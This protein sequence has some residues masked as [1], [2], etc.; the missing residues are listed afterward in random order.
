MDVLSPEDDDSKRVHHSLKNSDGEYRFE[1]YDRIMEQLNKY[2][3]YRNN[4]PT[5]KEK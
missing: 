1:N 2:I 5:K 3:G 4:E